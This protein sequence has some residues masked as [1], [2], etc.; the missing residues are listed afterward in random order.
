MSACGER[1]GWPMASETMSRAI[2]APSD[3]VFHAVSA[4]GSYPE[5]F[6][7]V[8]KVEFLGEQREGRGTRFRET[9]F[10]SGR[11]GTSEVEVTDFVAGER[12][13]LEDE[14]LG[15]KWTTTYA[16]ADEGG[17]TRLT[18]T[19]QAEPQKLMARLTMALSMSGYRKNMEKHL[20]TIKAHCE[21]AT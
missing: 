19:V 18:M 14:S 9:R 12:I 20:D 21:A 3:T 7:S 6:P 16:V 11:D 15:S 2:A 10:A 1:Y 17:N 5:T 13:Q 8:T 4:I